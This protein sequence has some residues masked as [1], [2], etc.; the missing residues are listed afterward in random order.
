MLL[1]CLVALSTSPVMADTKVSASKTYKAS[2]AASSSYPDT[3]GSELTDG[4]YALSATYTDPAWQGR[5]SKSYRHT[6]NLGSPQSINRVNTDFMADASVGI[7]YPTSVKCAYSTDGVNFKNLGTAAAL[8]EVSN[9]RQYQWTGTAVTAQYVQVT[10]AGNGSWIFQDEIEVWSASTLSAPTKLQYPQITLNATVGSPVA[11]DTPTVTGSVS[12]WSINPA[13]PAGLSLSTA[14]GSISGT[15][16]VASSTTAYTVTA[17]NSYGSTTATVTAT[18]VD[19]A[20]IP[21]GSLSYPA[22]SLAGVVGSPVPTDTPTYQGTVTFWS[23][24]PALPAGLALNPSNG[25]ISGTPTTAQAAS[26]YTVTA[27]SSLGTTT[28]TLSIAIKPATGGI[29]NPI[30]GVTVDD[31]WTDNATNR[32]KLISALQSCPVKPTVRIVMDNNIQPSSYTSLFQAIHNVAYV[33]ACPCDSTYMASY[34]TVDAYR[35]RF[36]DSVAALG[37]Y[38]D[39]W[40]VG[41]EINGEG[42]LGNDKQFVADKMYAAYTYIH[43]LG[44]KT[45]LTPYEFR[46][47]DQ[48][49]TMEA[50][51]QT[52]VPQ[53]M[54]L[55]VDYVMV[56]YYEDDNGGYQPTWSTVFSDLQTLFPNAKLGIGECGNTAT[57][58]TTTSKINMAQ[59]Y[60]GMPKYLPSYVGGY[61]W[62]YWAEDCVISSDPTGAATIKSAIDADMAAQPQ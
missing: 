47:G 24:L 16:T 12:S 36:S 52:Y 38:V 7:A 56:S 54:K 27:G 28:A 22:T 60:Y 41:N 15:P 4:Q 23:V 49:M 45:V 32:S 42:W 33:M 21:P 43:G 44:L 6:I 18:V 20:M 61:F 26:S 2:A 5:T 59:H 48:S 57:T 10:V 51:L 11:A 25:A 3:N 13:L 50:W 55:G 34:T 8:A 9:R 39:L 29:P 17:A 35:K 1:A 31:G 37:P 53:D 40:E 58:A 62:W 14:N 19:P 46:P 30:H